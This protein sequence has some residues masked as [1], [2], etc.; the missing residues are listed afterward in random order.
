MSDRSQGEGWWQASDDKWYPPES[1][2]DHRPNAPPQPGADPGLGPPPTGAPVS[3]P[4]S[5]AGQIDHPQGTTILV[6][7]ILGLVVCGVL[8]PVA[9]IMGNNTLAEID[10]D[11]GR[12]GNRGNVVAGRICGIIAT[13]FLALGALFLVVFFIA[14]A[15]SGTG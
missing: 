2:P 9:W 5:Y 15:A 6:L 3:Y 12:Y 8:G 11:P 13:A 4:P 1:H 7:G 10:A 14:I